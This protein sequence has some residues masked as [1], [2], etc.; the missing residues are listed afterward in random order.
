MNNRVLTAINPPAA[1]LQEGRVISSSMLIANGEVE[2]Q[3]VSVGP[4]RYKTT[5]YPPNIQRL[6]VI[7]CNDVPQCFNE[8]R[9]RSRVWRDFAMEEASFEQ[10]REMREGGDMVIDLTQ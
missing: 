3:R 2:P 4:V 10:R 5:Y 1:A 6:V 8:E 9:I 7:I